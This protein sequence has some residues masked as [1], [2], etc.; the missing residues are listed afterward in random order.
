MAIAVVWASPNQDGL[1]ASA[2]DRI[3]DGIAAAGFES[4]VIHL[5]EFGI[6]SCLACED[7][8]GICRSEGKCIIEDGFAQVYDRLAAA[9]GIVFV[10]P[11]YWHDLA[12]CLKSYLDRLRRCET[13][14][15]HFLKDKECLLVACAGGSGNGVIECLDHLE[16][17][18]NHMGMVALDRLPVIQFNKGYLLPALSSAGEAF[19]SHLRKV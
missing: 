19:A 16:I 4:E 10:T 15:N 13:K 1:T 12:E 11:V 5:N 17:T 7:G 3:L 2:K 9:E 18:L 6:Q 14:H 8:Y